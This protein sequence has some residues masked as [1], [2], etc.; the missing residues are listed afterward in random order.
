MCSCGIQ[1]INTWV[2]TQPI[3]ILVDYFNSMFDIKVIFLK[4]ESPFCQLP[5]EL[6]KLHEQFQW[7]VICDQNE[8]ATKQ[9]ILECGDNPHGCQRF[10]FIFIWIIFDVWLAIGLTCIS[11]HVKL[12]I[13]FIKLCENHSK[14]QNT[15]IY[16]QLEGM[17]S[18][19]SLQN[20]CRIK[21]TSLQ[22]LKSLLLCIPPNELFINLGQLS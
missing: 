9:I 18:N 2:P 22:L 3:C 4:N 6:I 7:L 11:H 17:A 1:V 5:H 21:P 19:R 14:T 15:P 8:W 20:G 13:F 10:P 12:S 16:V